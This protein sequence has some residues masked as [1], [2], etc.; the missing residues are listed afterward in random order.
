MPLPI[1]YPLN[2][3]LLPN[4]SN[5]RNV[6]P[7]P[8]SLI[9][10]L[11][12]YNQLPLNLLV[13]H[14][15]N[16]SP[17]IFPELSTNPIRQFTLPNRQPLP[18]RSHEGDKLILERNFPKIF[19]HYPMVLLNKEAF[20][21]GNANWHSWSPQ[22]PRIIRHEGFNKL[23]RH[24]REDECISCIRAIRLL[25][26]RVHEDTQRIR[27]S[28]NIN[29]LIKRLI[30]LIISNDSPPP[31]TTLYLEASRRSISIPLRLAIIFNVPNKLLY[32]LSRLL[33]RSISHPQYL[34][35][36]LTLPHII[37]YLQ[38]MLPRHIQR[39]CRLIL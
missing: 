20:P 28:L 25:T 5:E 32:N 19:R 3:T 6:L 38:I 1:K 27:H 15:P 23:S 36:L 31:N 8:D 2:D 26:I 37:N 16:H 18:H 39:Q 4:A 12:P 11:I 17:F 21:W 33:R 34:A 22:L 9:N 14:I 24:E 30:T 10:Y 13:H 35:A 7:W 29:L